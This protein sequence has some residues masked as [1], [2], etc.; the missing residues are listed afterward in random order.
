MT[1]TQNDF[2]TLLQSV[3][4]LTE[5]GHPKWSDDQ[6]DELR[7]QE[8]SARRWR[9]YVAEYCNWL[10]PKEEYAKKLA[11]NRKKSMAACGRKVKCFEP[12][13]CT[14]SEKPWF[15]KRKDCYKCAHRQLEELRQSLVEYAYLYQKTIISKEEQAG[16]VKKLK[17]QGRKYKAIPQGDDSVLLITEGAINDS[18]SLLNDRDVE[19][20]ELPK[21]GRRISGKLTANPPQ[22]KEEQIDDR[23]DIYVQEFIPDE[24]ISDKEI[25]ADTLAYAK[26]LTEPTDRREMQIMVHKIEKYM[27]ARYDEAGIDVLYLRKSIKKVN[28]LNVEWG[29]PIPLYNP[30]KK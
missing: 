6:I 8:T 1:T 9:E 21:E 26:T 10:D 3:P 24:E 12:Q 13:S 18:S 22:P 7:A 27:F 23:V 19:K 14:I 5:D 11:E 2:L 30:D 28:I 25:I 17:A 16:L 15:C 29:V 20:I 4:P